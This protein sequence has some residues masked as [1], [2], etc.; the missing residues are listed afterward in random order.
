MYFLSYPENMDLFSWKYKFY[1][2]EDNQIKD[3]K[4]FSPYTQF[5][6]KG[7]EFEDSK[8]TKKYLVVIDDQNKNIVSSMNWKRYLFGFDSHYHDQNVI[9]VYDQKRNKFFKK[10][11]FCQNCKHYKRRLSKIW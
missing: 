9:F 3:C 6:T 11:D 7:F 2:I 10:C 5:K 1:D 8:K 4:M